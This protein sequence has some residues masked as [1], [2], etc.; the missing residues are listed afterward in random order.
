MKTLEQIEEL[1]ERKSVIE[2]ALCWEKFRNL[3]TVVR[4]T[5]NQKRKLETTKAELTKELDPIQE[6]LKKYNENVQAVKTEGELV[7]KELR[8]K[9]SQVE[10]FDIY[11][12]E[13]EL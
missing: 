9:G 3:R 8:M 7:E 12:L 5:R 4:E 11:Q 1:E 2:K 13:D 10:G 6:F